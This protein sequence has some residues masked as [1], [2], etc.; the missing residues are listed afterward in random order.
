MAN[1]LEKY[2]W[3]LVGVAVG[4][5]A[6]Y[7]YYYFI[8]CNSG[9]CPIQ[10]HWHTSTLYGGLIGYVFSNSPKKDKSERKQGV[11]QKKEE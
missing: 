1:F 6:G 11:S 4:A 10:S 5:V 7:A 9:T 8:G 3:K 2:K